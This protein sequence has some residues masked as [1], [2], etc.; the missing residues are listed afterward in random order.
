MTTHAELVQ[1]AARWLSSSGCV[2]VLSEANCWA[3]DEFPDAIGWKLHGYSILVECKM[4]RS[5]FQ[6]DMHK[7]S[8]QRARRQGTSTM[9]RERWYFAPQGLLKPEDMPEGYG[10]IEKVG[11]KVDV[12]HPADTEERAGR[13]RAE[14]PLLI[15]AARKQAWANGCKG[16]HVR[17]ETVTPKPPMRAQG[18][19]AV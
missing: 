17:L 5:D 10:L 13:Q 18:R 8:K 4:S 2:L 1:R 11:R 3:I 14:M 16:R 7:S 15:H 19:L 12:V 9:G 6:R